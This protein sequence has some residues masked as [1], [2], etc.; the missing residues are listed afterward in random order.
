MIRLI[1]ILI[2]SA[3]AVGF[4]IVTFGVPELEAPQADSVLP[5]EAE[6][7][8]ESAP[9][10][11]AVAELQAVPEVDTTIIRSPQVE[12]PVEAPVTTPVDATAPAATDDTL[13]VPQ[14]ERWYA[15]WS[16]FR[17]EI[18]ANGFV[19]QLQR[20]TGL[21]YR[22]VK[23]KPGV[24]EVAFAYAD[25]SDIQNKLAQISTATGLDLTGG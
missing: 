21:D 12:Q 10:E 22:I 6:I 1:G 4:L 19:S 20:T 9:R 23:V 5:V 3:F 16:P 15:F 17:S 7:H 2:G 8:A 13:P 24:Y 14:E 25:D 18:A 11:E